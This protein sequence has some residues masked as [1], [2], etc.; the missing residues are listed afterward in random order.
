MPISALWA[1][2][3]PATQALITREV[4]PDVQGRM[5]GALMSLIS[6]AGIVAPALFAGT[7]GFFIGSRTPSYQP[8]AAFLLA[9]VVLATALVIAVRHAPRPGPAAG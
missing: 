2:A 4:G 7:F 6:L 9:A 8:G 3:Q 1:I 5:Q